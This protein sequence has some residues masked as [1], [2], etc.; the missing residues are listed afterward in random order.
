MA[1]GEKVSGIIVS[2]AAGGAG[3]LRWQGK[4]LFIDYTAPG[5]LVSAVIT[6]ETPSWGRATLQKIHE[7]S[8]HRTQSPCPYYQHCGGCNLQHLTYTMQL[9]I[10]QQLLQD[11]FTRI[12][13]INRL[14]HINIVASEPYGYRNR[15]QFHRVPKPKTGQSRVGLK[16]RSSD[17]VLPIETCPI[18]NAGIQRALQAKELVPPPAL[19]RFTVYSR[20]DMFL[21]EGKQQRGTVPLLGAPIHMDAGVFFQSNAQVLE[22]L[23]ETVRSVAAQADH[24]LPA[25]DLYCGVGTFAYFIQDIF[26]ALDLMEENPKALALAKENITHSQARYFAVSDEQWAKQALTKHQAH[27]YGFMVLDPPREGLSPSLRNYLSTEGPPL[28]AYVSCDPA[29]QARDC[30]SL[31]Q[32]GYTLERLEFYDFYPQTSHIESLAVLRRA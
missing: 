15:M 22:K 24:S 18:A 17:Q 3:I 31:V 4:T 30:K 11:H 12:G 29:T 32:A 7:A 14:P 20:F 25:G 21:Q 5:D 8:P 23:L 28:I 10:K 16:E 2:I 1:I 19:D 13:G 9:Q 27:R 26:S 6:E